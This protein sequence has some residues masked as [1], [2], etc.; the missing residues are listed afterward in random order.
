M[1]M[2]KLTLLT[3]GNCPL[4]VR[5]DL[6]NCTAASDSQICFRVSGCYTGL[7]SESEYNR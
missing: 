2:K 1:C 4:W 6:L 5:P 7:H 3:S